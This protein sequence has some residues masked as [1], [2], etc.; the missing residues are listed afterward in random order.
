[1]EKMASWRLEINFRIRRPRLPE[2]FNS[3][4]LEIFAEGTDGLTTGR[5]DPG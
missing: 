1:M 4:V 2:R 5:A 3:L